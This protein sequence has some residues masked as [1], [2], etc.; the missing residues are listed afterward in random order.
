MFFMSLVSVI[1]PCY[2]EEKHITNLLNA[3]KNQTYLTKNIEIIIA[4]GNSI[5]DTLLK[6]KLFMQN[7]PEINIITLRNNKKIIPAALNQAIRASAGD[8][9]IRMDAH[10]LPNA[11]YIERCIQHLVAGDADN[12]GGLWLIQP[13]SNSLI[14]KSIAFAAS[15]PFGVGD[16]KYRYSSESDYV[17]TVPYGAYKRTLI[18]KIGLFDENLLAN[19]DYELNTR[20]LKNGGRIL[21]DPN[22]QTKYIARE[23]LNA[24][25]KQYF[26]YGYWKFRMLQKYPESLRWRQAIP[27]LFVISIL[28]GSIIAVFIRIFRFILLIELLFYFGLLILSSIR[29][30]KNEKNPGLL[31][32]VPIAILTMHFGWGLGFLKSTL[33]LIIQKMRDVWRQ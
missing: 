1:I 24:L 28:M 2:N 6:I 5:D 4:D 13:A 22:I 21:F 32:G 23:N 18:Q 8:F 25:W 15:H 20:I 14:A 29:I 33:S 12:V 31:I 11:D 26:N 30:V 19:E 16:A 9:I 7:N 27:P 10:S 3:L 17:E